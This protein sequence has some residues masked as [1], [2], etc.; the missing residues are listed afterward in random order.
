MVI[1]LDAITSASLATY[2]DTRGDWLA[3]SIGDTTY[4]FCIGMGFFIFTN[5][6]WCSGRKTRT[7]HNAVSNLLAPP[8]GAPPP[9][10]GRNP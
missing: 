6:P 8:D 3:L 9:R 7:W 10:T 1:P 4:D 2:D 5:L